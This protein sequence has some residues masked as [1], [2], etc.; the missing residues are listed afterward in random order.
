M[1]KRRSIKEE[2]MVKLVRASFLLEKKSLA[3]VKRSRVEEMEKNR[4]GGD[5]KTH[6]S[7]K[8]LLILWRG[9][10]REKWKFLWQQRELRFGGR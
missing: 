5:E 4:G 7:S 8:R 3:N 10:R 2:A 9:G 6:S 1:A